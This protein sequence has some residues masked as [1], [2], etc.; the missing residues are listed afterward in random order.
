MTLTRDITIRQHNTTDIVTPVLDAD[1]PDAIFFDRVTDVTVEVVIFERGGDTET[2]LVTTDDVSSDVV[3][4]G[5]VPLGSDRF[6]VSGVP[7]VDADSFTIPDTQEVI[8]VTI[9]DATAGELPADGDL[10]FELRLFDSAESER[11]SPVAGDVTV[12][13]AAPFAEDTA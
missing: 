7:T 4:F 9:D 10:G 8:V 5:G 13:D 1:D 2:A 12:E 6:D 3:P 11:L